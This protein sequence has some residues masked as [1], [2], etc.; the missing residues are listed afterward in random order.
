V[1][2]TLPKLRGPPAE[3]L[4]AL[5]AILFDPISAAREK[6]SPRMTRLNV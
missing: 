1:H 6:D 5:R 3:P 2:E 4:P